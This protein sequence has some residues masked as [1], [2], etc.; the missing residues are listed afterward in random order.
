MVKIIDRGNAREATKILTNS[1]FTADNVMRAYKKDA[2]VVFPGVDVK[3]FTPP[4][5][6]SRNYFLF[7]GSKDEINGFG[8]LSEVIDKTQL[9][10]NIR[11]VPIDRSGFLISDKKM[12][13]LY[14]NAVAT[15]CLGKN[16]PFGLSRQ[17]PRYQPELLPWSGAALLTG[18]TAAVEQPL[19]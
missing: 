15:M 13:E 11:F 1:G 10:F 12:V 8:L 14:Q 4:P 7:V 17:C 18:L 3:L 19:N 16:E 6:S 5:K 2:E 9:P